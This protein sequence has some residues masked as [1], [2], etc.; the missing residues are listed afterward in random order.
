MNQ[1]LSAEQ[2]RDRRIEAR[3]TQVALAKKIGMHN[4][5]LCRYEGGRQIAL[6]VQIALDKVLRDE[7]QV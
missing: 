1:V 3:L 6:T 4:V 2:L 7:F 5:T